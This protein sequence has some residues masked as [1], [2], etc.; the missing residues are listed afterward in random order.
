MSKLEREFLEERPYQRG[1]SDM[2][3][4]VRK[5]KVTTTLKGCQYLEIAIMFLLK[6]PDRQVEDVI[7]EMARNLQA[8]QN[9]QVLRAIEM[10]SND[11][12]RVERLK[13][14]RKKEITK[15]EAIF[16]QMKAALQ[17]VN[18]KHAEKVQDENVVKYF[19]QNVVTEIRIRA[20][21]EIL[22]AN[23]ERGL[24]EKDKQIII[25]AAMRM[26][27]KAES[28]NDILIFLNKKHPSEDVVS[29]LCRIS[30]KMNFTSR[31]EMK[32]ESEN[33]LKLLL[34]DQKKI[35]F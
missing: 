1:Y 32:E 27:Q 4:L 2:R 5:A 6:N 34:E 23:L 26:Y 15:E 35:I 18:T 30:Q 29:I 21:L 7:A 33:V 14:F 13:K 12:M 31:D 9:A 17:T 10:D 8:E 3:T 25:E 28:I 20:S 11:K 22:E 24:N 16:I 19:I